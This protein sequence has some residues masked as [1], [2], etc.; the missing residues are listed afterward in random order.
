[1]GFK[2]PDWGEPSKTADAA[3]YQAPGAAAR[4][5][6][7]ILALLVRIGIVRGRF[8]AL[9]VRGRKSGKTISLPVAARRPTR[10]RS[11]TLRCLCTRR[12]DI[13]AQCP[14]G[15]RGRVGAVNAAMVVCRARAFAGAPPL[16][17]RLIAIDTRA[18]SSVS[19]RSAGGRL[20]D[21]RSGFCLLNGTVGVLN[22]K[23]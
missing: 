19:F 15:R 8:F 23:R 9:E 22:N 16:S 21:P 4:N 14:R 18:R 13:G 5:L 10:P 17:S 3:R 1:M 2:L 12:V 20:S 11:Q 6:G 7:R